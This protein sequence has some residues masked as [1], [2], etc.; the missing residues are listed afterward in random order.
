V[1]AAAPAALEVRASK[2]LQGTVV[3]TKREQ[4]VAV[5]V[6]RIAPHPLYKKRIITTKRYHVHDPENQ[7]QVGDFVTLGKCAPISKSKR[8]VVIDV[9]KARMT[10]SSAQMLQGLG[11]TAGTVAAGKPLPPLQSESQ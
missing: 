6:K 5:D 3:N 9:R 4:T 2:K 7:C 8:F 1:Q 11:S 10:S